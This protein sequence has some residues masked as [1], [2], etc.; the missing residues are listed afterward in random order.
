MIEDN[1]QRQLDE[2]RQIQVEL[3]RVHGQSLQVLHSCCFQVILN[4]TLLFPFLLGCMELLFHFIITLCVNLKCFCQMFQQKG[5]EGLNLSSAHTPHGT[6]GQQGATMSMQGQVVP[7][8][9]LQNNMQQ[10][11]AVQTQTQSQQQTLLRDQ[12]T[13]MSQVRH[14]KIF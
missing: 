8:A 6:A 11:Q 7:P 12:S 9:A 5:D 14:T 1:I 2:L 4:T 10:Q 13:V 3:E